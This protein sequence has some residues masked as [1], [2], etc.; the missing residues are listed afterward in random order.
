[1]EWRN[2]LGRDIELVSIDGGRELISSVGFAYV[3]YTNVPLKIVDGIQIVGQDK[4]CFIV[5]LPKES[6]KG[7]AYIVSKDVQL[8]LRGT[9][10]DIYS[11][12]ERPNNS[13]EFNEENNLIAYKCLVASE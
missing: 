10:K 12:G 11:L 7:V 8:H 6:K 3:Q 1:M 4:F 5:G 13:P 2:Y 9:R